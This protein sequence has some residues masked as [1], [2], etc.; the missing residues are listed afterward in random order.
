MTAASGD[1]AYVLCECDSSGLTCRCHDLPAAG[2][3]VTAQT[4]LVANPADGTL[5]IQAGQQ[6][7]YRF[8]P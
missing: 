4:Q 6:T 2:Q 3:P 8:S 7:V 5:T 1:S